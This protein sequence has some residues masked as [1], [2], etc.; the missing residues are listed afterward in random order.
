MNSQVSQVSTS[1]VSN[2]PQQSTST[3]VVITQTPI[4]INVPERPKPL[5]EAE[6]IVALIESPT[7]INQTT[8]CGHRNYS[9]IGAGGGLMYPDGISRSSR[10]GLYVKGGRSWAYAT[11]YEERILYWNDWL[12]L[13]PDLKEAIEEHEKTRLLDKIS[14]FGS[15]LLLSDQE[16]AQKYASWNYDSA[17]EIRDSI[18]HAYDHWSGIKANTKVVFDGYP[19]L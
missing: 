7:D 10:S 16:L 2:I 13:S 18:Q 12:G 6:K 14:D 17:Q 11:K 19:L 5:T 15:D 9:E 8:G 1:T 4:I 3:P